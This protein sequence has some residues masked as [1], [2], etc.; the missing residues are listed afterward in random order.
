MIYLDNAATT[1][2]SEPALAALV[3]VSKKQF[4]NASSAYK[5]GRDAKI[6][7]E[8]SR[9]IIA[10]CIGANPDE[11]YFTSGGTESNNWVVNQVKH[12]VERI[13]IS[14]VEHHA[15]SLPVERAKLDG[16]DVVVIPVDQQC[17][18]I[19]DELLSALSDGKKTL[20]SIMF[21]NNE[22]GV[23]QDI[24]S[25]AKNVHMLNPKSI[26]HTDAVQAIGHR[27]VNVR[28]FGVDMLSASAHKFNGP[29]GVGF[30][31]IRNECSIPPF[32]LGG[33][34]EKGLRS[35]TE[36]VAS[37]YSMAK[38]LEDN[39]SHIDDV[40]KHIR[41]LETVLLRELSSN[42]IP[43]I[44]NGDITTKAPGII[45]ISIKGIDGEG[46]LNMLDVHDIC[47]SIGSA[48]NS[49]TKNRSEVLLA[50]GLDNERIDSSF[51]VSI[52]RFNKETEIHELVKY[53]KKYYELS[54]LA[55]K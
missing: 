27:K 16:V 45:N 48:C 21:Q 15:V 39:I 53:I 31:Y 4:G 32:I 2:M 37:I 9:S 54:V 28:D 26:F 19:A 14:S 22:T 24:S 20:V 52:G 50:M 13:V 1:Q 46:L 41:E 40:E 11:I 43:Y 12:S 34:Q 23:I 33:G 38:A 29:K 35:G 51:R 7:L 3:E 42:N 10:N 6:I 17:N 8:E 5:Y 18:T 55:Q 49:K 44:I 30:L 25:F 36:N 47:V